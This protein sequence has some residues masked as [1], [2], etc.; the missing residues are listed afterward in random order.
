MAT[1][2]LRSSVN[3][4]VS[5]GP[6]MARTAHVGSRKSPPS[7]QPHDTAAWSQPVNHRK[8]ELAGTAPRSR[9]VQIRSHRRARVNERFARNC[10]IRRGQ[11]GAG[12]RRGADPRHF[13]RELWRQG[14]RSNRLVVLAVLQHPPRQ[15]IYPNLT[16]IIC[17]LDQR[18]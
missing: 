3:R 8:I 7:S 6:A 11:E 9:Q 13:G 17:G 12:I 10:R 15:T 14:H 4:T 1:A 16:Q 2:S 18:A 5:F